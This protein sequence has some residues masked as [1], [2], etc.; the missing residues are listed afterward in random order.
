MKK[1]F[2]SI[3]VCILATS[4]K[5]DSVTSY[6]LFTY[7]PPQEIEYGV[8]NPKVTVEEVDFD[9][10]STAISTLSNRYTSIRKGLLEQLEKDNAQISNA[11]RAALMSLASETHTLA[12]FTHPEDFDVEEFMTNAQKYGFQSDELK[13]FIEENHLSV[14]F[15][16]LDG[17]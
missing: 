12:I 7:T 8:T 13:Q 2:L 16:N 6:I 11:E 3:I 5:N 17:I 9:N 10:D 1:L 14:T 15:K 4:C